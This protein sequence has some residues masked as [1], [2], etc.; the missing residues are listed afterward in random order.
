MI[1]DYLKAQGIEALSRGAREYASIVMGGDMG[2]Y[3]ILVPEDQYELAKKYLAQ[4]EFEVLKSP[5][6]AND[7]DTSPNPINKNSAALKKSV[8]LC[9]AGLVVLPLFNVFSLYYLL[10]YARAAENSFS[11]FISLFL[12]LVFNAAAV[13]VY[14]KV[15]GQNLLN[16]FF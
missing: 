4:L 3:E 1:V 16:R 10:V 8:L 11:K 7:A 13:F 5:P 15:I 14:Y 6:D 9:A 2:R 12:L